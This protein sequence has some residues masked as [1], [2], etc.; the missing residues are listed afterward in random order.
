VCVCVCVCIWG[1][2][3]VC[4]CVC[5]YIYM[6]KLNDDSTRLSRFAKCVW[7]RESV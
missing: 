3:Y 5:G 7:E 2:R 4:V 1:W 6:R